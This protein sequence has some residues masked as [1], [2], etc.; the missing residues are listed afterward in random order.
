MSESTRTSRAAT[1][2]HGEQDS[3]AGRV[4]TGESGAKQ[5]RRAFLGAIG[6][7]VAATVAVPSVARGQTTPTISMGNNYFD[8]IGLAVEPGTTVRFVIEDGAHS[9]TAY[10]DRIPSG[11]A[12]FDSGTLS[13]GDFEHTFDT[14]GTY[15]YYCRPH[16][17]MGMTGRIVVGEPGGPAETASIP[18][19][20]VP[21]SDEIRAQGKVG[22]DEFDGAGTDG[23][24]GMMNG[25]SRMGGGGHGWHPLVPVGVGTTLLGLVGGALY[26]SSRQR[27]A[28]PNQA[29]PAIETLERR[30]AQGEID[31]AEFERRLDRLREDVE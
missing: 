31:E 16:K 7:G 21:A 25:K 4:A 28:E 8:P 12:A 18:D 5:S 17:S 9:A 20:N 19:G 6:S 13:A 10:E 3:H 27:T 11:A 22:V 24:G 15:D 1:R 29:T 23:R 30:Y 14:P 26:W 2:R